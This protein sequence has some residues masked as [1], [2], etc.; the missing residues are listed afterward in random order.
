MN[1]RLYEEY[2]ATIFRKQKWFS[3]INRQRAY[4]IMLN[5]IVEKFS[6]DKENPGSDLVIIYGDWSIGKQMRNFISTP[7]L[8]V[9]NKVANR[10]KMYDID[11]YNTS[12]LHNITGNPCSNLSLPD[13]TGKYHE[14]HAILTYK[15][16]NG[17]VGCINRDK[18]S[19]RNMKTI[20]QS[21][22][23]GNG[24]PERFQRSEK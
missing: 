7:N 15:M 11:E 20:T 12:K 9:K 8:T 6:C 16:E 19:V 4:D 17:R 21:L 2:E 3:F 13:K 24:R 23:A 5:K 10:L 1:E 18:N 22:I 14:I